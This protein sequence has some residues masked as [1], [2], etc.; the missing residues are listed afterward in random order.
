[1]RTAAAAP[2]DEPATAPPEQGDGSLDDDLRT[3]AA[4]VAA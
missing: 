1:M 3:A 4:D 2:L